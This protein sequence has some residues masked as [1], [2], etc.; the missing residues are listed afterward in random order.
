[1]KYLTAILSLML[2]ALAV[3]AGPVDPAVARRAA[4][5]V[6]GRP[7][8]DATPASWTGCRLFHG[9][10]GTG[11]VLLSA[12]DCAMPLLAYSPAGLFP[13]DEAL[14]PRHVSDWI[15]GYRRQIA[16]AGPAAPSPQVSAA[17]HALL[18]PLPMPKSDT[19][20]PL[21]TTTWGQGAYYNR[22]C[23]GGSSVGCVA[24]ALGQ[25][26]HYWGH[27]A[28]GRGSHAYYSYAAGDTLRVDFAAANYQWNL[29]PNALSAA[30]PSESVDAVARLLADLGYGV[31]MQYGPGVSLAYVSSYA[32][33]D[34]ASAESVLR[35]H[36][37]YSPALHSAFKNGHTDSSWRALAK[38]EL[39]AGRPI[40]Y[41]GYSAA[42]SGHAFVV[43]GYDSRQ[44]FHVNWGWNGSYDGF[45][46]IDSLLIQSPSGS[47][48]GYAYNNEM[49][50][51]IAPVQPLETQYQLSGVSA[52]TARGNVAGSATVG[53]GSLRAT[54]LAA[55]SEGY[56][57]DHWSSGAV[58]NPRLYSPTADLYDTAHFRPLGGDTVA[59]CRDYGYDW[60]GVGATGELAWGIR[61]PASLIPRHRQLQ[62]VQFVVVDTGTYSLRIYSGTTPNTVLHAE[63][64]TFS[65]G[66]WQTVEI[67][68]PM[69]V[70]DTAPLWITLHAS[71]VGTAT[72]RSLYTG[73]A[74][75]TYILDGSTWRPSHEVDGTYGTWMIRAIFA[76]AEKVSLT[77][78]S[79]N[80]SWG[81]VTGGGLYYPGDT[82][83][84]EAI[85][86]ERN[87]YFDQWSDGSTDN[88]YSFVIETD[89]ALTAIFATGNGIDDATADG[90]RI[91]VDGL[92]LTVENPHGHPLALYDITGRPLLNNQAFRQSSVQTFT[93]PG[94]GVYILQVPGLPARRIVA[95]K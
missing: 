89:L 88:P 50:V 19:V 42:G 11:F 2:L 61:I 28:S 40:L 30:S 75:G 52:D 14:M 48:A 69:P 27:P 1:M 57:F 16:A 95:M 12:D 32:S 43:D 10:D 29:M 5:N 49:I 79:N 71:G 85:A 80:N 41:S 55:A 35:E 60:Y 66:G 6:L 8:V 62:E 83:T 37:N 17:W 3:Q 73:N 92:T 64:Y 72:Q 94:S 84:V 70:F 21:L 65:S 54:L 31:S 26:L 68:Y 82:V 33:L 58:N 76:E 4:E 24:V 7:V 87:C 53:S 25:I 74:D 34:S 38:A 67:G 78:R 44:L 51:G 22:F 77:V 45:Y 90:L 59:Y 18:A 15:A 13:A 20:A 36:F 39:D 81:Q 63:S 93:L 91:A 23:P 9:A 47:H 86:S 46:S 56:V